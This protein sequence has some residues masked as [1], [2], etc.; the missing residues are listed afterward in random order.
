MMAKTKEPLQIKLSFSLEHY[1]I[2]CFI[3]RISSQLLK[4]HGQWRWAAR[5]TATQH[6]RKSHTIDTS[7]WGW[8]GPG[9]LLVSVL[10][11]AHINKAD[12]AV[13]ITKLY[14]YSQSA[15]S[16]PLYIPHRQNARPPL[17]SLGWQA[18]SLY[19]SDCTGRSCVP[20]YLPLLYR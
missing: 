4:C 3:F 13:K 16:I 6:S 18:P 2:T 8:N 11:L 17:W 1:T 10:V 5:G 20:A 7:R 19:C 12:G 15:Y 9:N 14:T